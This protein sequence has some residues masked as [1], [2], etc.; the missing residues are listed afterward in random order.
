MVG[1]VLGGRK[2]LIIVTTAKKRFQ[3]RY[4]MPCPALQAALHAQPIIL[5][6]SVPFGFP[7]SSACADRMYTP[8]GG[9]APSVLLGASPSSPW[10]PQG[11]VPAQWC[12]VR[13]CARWPV[14]LAQSAGGRARRAVPCC[15]MPRGS[16]G[17]CVDASVRLPGTRVAWLGPALSVAWRFSGIPVL[18]AAT[19]VL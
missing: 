3:I 17:V 9:K 5:Y 10:E 14:A 12:A 16:G 2:V 4:N 6:L 18:V 1:R 15:A 11:A 19:S 13:A 7:F 8:I